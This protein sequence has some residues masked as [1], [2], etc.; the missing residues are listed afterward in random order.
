M[1]I[2]SI[3]K[4]LSFWEYQK[5]L[6]CDPE[7]PRPVLLTLSYRNTSLV[8]YSPI[9]EVH[10][11]EMEKQDPALDQ[12]CFCFPSLVS[13][14]VLVSALLS[15]TLLLVIHMCCSIVTLSVSTFFF[16]IMP[17]NSPGTHCCLGTILMVTAATHFC[18]AQSPIIPRHSTSWKHLP[19]LRDFFGWL[20]RPVGSPCCS[21]TGLNTCSLCHHWQGQQDQVPHRVSATSLWNIFTDV[22][23]VYGWGLVRWHWLSFL[24]FLNPKLIPFELK[25]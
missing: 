6:A 21:W 7:A 13:R 14:S 25:A 4:P 8:K 2:S 11:Q 9:H 20:A 22:F 24:C 1:T 12:W 19:G 15:S 18:A 10:V 5:Y 23:M 3:C 17:S 16:F